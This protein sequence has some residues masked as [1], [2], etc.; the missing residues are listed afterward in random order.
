MELSDNISLTAGSH[1]LTFGTHGELIRLPTHENLAYFFAPRWHFQS[2]DSLA[3]GLPDRYEG[4]V[5]HPV[6]QDGPLS[7]LRTQLFSPYVQDQWSVT[8][9]LLL[10]AGIRVDAPFVSRQPV[11]NPALLE[12]PSYGY[13]SS[14]L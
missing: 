6:R 13:T 3:A 7:D 4:I 9:K 8:P 5:E 1:R 10:T 12:S 11:R 14:V 2:L